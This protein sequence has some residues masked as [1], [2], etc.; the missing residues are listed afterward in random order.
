MTTL[1][2]KIG[3]ITVS[4]VK[5]VGGSVPERITPDPDP[6]SLKM[7]GSNKLKNV[8]IRSNPYP[9]LVTKGAISWWLHDD[10]LCK[11]TIHS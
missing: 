1:K 3:L 11:V 6:S 5:E 2:F 4:A 9:Q 10:L 8:R 7:A